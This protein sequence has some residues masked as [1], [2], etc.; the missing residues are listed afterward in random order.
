MN[1]CCVHLSAA[2]LQVEAIHVRCSLVPEEN[3]R[4]HKVQRHLQQVQDGFA[5][6][7]ADGVADAVKRD[8]GEEKDEKNE[9]GSRNGAACAKG[10][11]SGIVGDNSL[12]EESAVHKGN[13]AERQ[14]RGVPV[15]NGPA[16]PFYILQ[17]H[18]A[19]A[20][21]FLQHIRLS[22]LS[23]TCLLRRVRAYSTHTVHGKQ[24]NG[25]PRHCNCNGCIPDQLQRRERAKRWCSSE[26]LASHPHLLWHVLPIWKS[27]ADPQ[28]AAVRHMMPMHER[29][30]GSGH[31]EVHFQ[32]H[33]QARC[34]L[35]GM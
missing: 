1:P 9:V 25:A 13:Y 23:T 24:C 28:D 31:E 26:V 6:V 18:H 10:I 32:G 5:A 16:L 8:V 21:C 30:L 12:A 27:F 11:D 34:R 3:P 7:G 35:G 29:Q 19:P 2:H 20:H 15:F 4:P 33:G 17:P 14:R 22:V